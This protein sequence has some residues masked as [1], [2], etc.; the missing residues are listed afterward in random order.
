MGFFEKIS[1]SPTEKKVA[2]YFKEKDRKAKAELGPNRKILPEVKSLTLSLFDFSRETD[3]DWFQTAEAFKQY[4]DVAK[5]GD[6]IEDLRIATQGHCISYAKYLYSLPE[7]HPYIST[8]DNLTFHWW[9]LFEDLRDMYL[10]GKYVNLEPSEISDIV[11]TLGTIDLMIV[12][13][14]KGTSDLE[15]WKKNRET[16][17]V[18]YPALPSIE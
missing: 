13:K 11:D 12:S 14:F 1:R 17:R 4:K 3:S 16:S 6:S 18:Q 8:F 15:G 2:A 9:K 10:V 7:N 5:K